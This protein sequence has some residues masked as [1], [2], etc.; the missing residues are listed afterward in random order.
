MKNILSVSKDQII[1]DLILLKN[2]TEE[3]ALKII[4]R[5]NNLILCGYKHIQKMEIEEDTYYFITA[6]NEQFFRDE[7]GV[8]FYSF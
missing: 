2:K 4:D 5:I 7:I 6:E 3:E 1:E 8:N